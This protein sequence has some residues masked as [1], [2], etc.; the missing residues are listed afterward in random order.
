MRIEDGFQPT[1]F[2]EQN[3]YLE[4]P[5]LPSLLK[6]LL[7]ASVLEEIE[8]DLRRLGDDVINVIR[9]LASSSEVCPP[10]ITQY[11]QWGRRVDVLHTSEGWR[12]LKGVAQREG[13]PGIFYERKFGEHSRIYGFAK[14]LLLVGDT[15]EVFCPISMTDGTARI[16]EILGN[17]ELKREVLPRLISRDPEVAFT[18]GQW[19]TERPGGSDVSLTETTATCKNETHAYGDKYSLNGIKWFSSATDSQISVALARTGSL[20]A[21][22]RGLSL[23]LIPLRLPLF[24]SPSAPPPSPVSNG[25]FVHRLKNKIGTHALPTAELSLRDTE[26]YL[27]S[28]VNEGV[29]HITPVLNITR[30]WSAVTSAGHL[31]K[32]L[33]IATAYAKVRAI[34]SGKTLLQDSPIHVAHLA[35]ISTLYRALVHLVF[36]VVGLMGKVECGVASEEEKRRLRMMTPVV[37]AFC[38]E[39]GVGG[40]EEA[41][42][43]LGGA[44]YMEENGLGRAVRDGLVEKIWEG[45][46]TVLALDLCRSA[47]DASN[48]KAFVQWAEDILGSTHTSFE[49]AHRQAVTLV[50]EALKAVQKVYTKPIKEVT[51]RPALLV[52]GFVASAVYLLEHANWAVKHNEPTRDVDV[53]VF[54]RWVLE[55]GFCK[56]L[57]ALVRSMQ[58]DEAKSQL[59]RRI[60]F[61]REATRTKL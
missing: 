61:G 9:P 58:T 16:I 33:S 37:K 30:L 18:A 54:Q 25:I 40:V 6:R 14:V 28:P 59:D 13:I 50:L 53:E 48:M 35:E 31:R 46:V 52:V 24:P 26:G 11:D 10:S 4:D 39:R 42:T 36:G 32:G 38:A 57:D 43:A 22:S 19:M 3:A 51:A 29:K 55:D 23:F 17:E 8:L 56:A 60:V 21:G 41:M 7:P 5:V 47:T 15:Q 2:A 12:K 20:S 27:I 49:Q 44:G 34:Q 1:P 45:T